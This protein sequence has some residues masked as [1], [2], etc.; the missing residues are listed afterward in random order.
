MLLGIRLGNCVGPCK[1]GVFT[2]DLTGVSI[3]A[4]VEDP[5]GTF[6]K[7]TVGNGA[8]ELLVKEEGVFV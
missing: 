1:T 5:S 6:V 4:S 2:G 8:F 3:G 7:F